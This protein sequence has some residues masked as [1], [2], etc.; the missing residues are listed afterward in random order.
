M[1]KLFIPYDLAL[2]LKG[3]GFKDPCL[4]F[5][6]AKGYLYNSLDFTNGY[7]TDKIY[8][9]E[10][11]APTFQEAFDWFIDNHKLFP[12]F[13]YQHWTKNYASMIYPDSF[14]V[15]DCTIHEARLKCLTRLIEIVE[16]RL[17]TNEDGRKID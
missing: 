12:D 5:Y 2:R 6:T 14:Y 16:L 9:N 8:H 13:C 10:C 11:L 17:K 7:T 4:S 3:I 1:K 15:H